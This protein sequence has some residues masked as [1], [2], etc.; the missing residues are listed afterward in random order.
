MFDYLDNDGSGVI[1]F[2]EFYQVI[3]V[4]ELCLSDKV[5][6]SHVLIYLY[7]KV[8]EWVFHGADTN[9]NESLDRQE[10]ADLLVAVYEMGGV[11]T[12]VH[13]PNVDGFFDR[14]DATQVNFYLV[15]YSF[16]PFLRNVAKN[17]PQMVILKPL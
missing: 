11:D 8:M 9:G 17:R 7:F 2:V 1:D 10:V 16:I 4:T 13:P 15:K 5:N 14:V 6:N 12:R 3:I